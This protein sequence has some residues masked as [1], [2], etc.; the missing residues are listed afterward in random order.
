MDRDKD[1]SV[2][3][4]AALIAE[5]SA[6]LQNEIKVLEAW[7]EELSAAN[8]ADQASQAARESYADMLT[9]RREM[10]DSLAQLVHLSNR[11]A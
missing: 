7:L 1:A 11:H 10:L 6:Q 9:S 3:I 8:A 5:G 4:D 2:S